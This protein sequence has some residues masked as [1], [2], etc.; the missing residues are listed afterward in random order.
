MAKFEERGM[1]LRL[2]EQGLSYS[3]IK[4]RVRV[5]KSTLSSWLR[6]HPLS[7]ERI[8]ELR[9]WSEQR[10][11]KFRMAMRR[12]REIRLASVY[13]NQ[14]VKLLP[15]SKKELLLTGLFLYA[16]EGA[17]S[18]PTDVALSNT[19]PIIIKFFISW[20]IKACGIERDS[21]KIRLHLYRDM[22]ISK[23]KRYW[24]G[25]TKLPENQFRKPYIK[26]NSIERI[27]YRGGFG[28]GTCNVIV[29]SVPLFEKIMMSIKVVLDSVAGA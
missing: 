23:E 17:K 29:S 10:I 28:H 11:E 24:M 4:Q 14:R 22:N 2:R 27:N 6:D 21:I 1:A 15:L 12:K 16:G 18:R 8:N 3:L 25:V 7:R 26:S 19:N 13:N 9:A 20:L 5:S